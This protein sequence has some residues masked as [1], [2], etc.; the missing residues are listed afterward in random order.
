MVNRV[1]KWPVR[2]AAV[3]V[4]RPDGKGA[5]AVCDPAE[6]PAGTGERL[7]AATLTRGERPEGSGFDPVLKQTECN[8]NWY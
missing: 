5:G 6:I 3:G 4:R 8:N 1:V 7:G 2:Q